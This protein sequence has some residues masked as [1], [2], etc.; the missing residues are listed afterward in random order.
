MN[1]FIAFMAS[2]TG[3][4]IRI[5]AGTAIMAWSLL[6]LHADSNTGLIITAMGAL[7]VLTGL[8]N[9]CLIAPLVG[10]PIAGSKA[11]NS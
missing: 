10:A 1:P 9:I 7:P 11:L 3:R 8:L 5:V 6:G 2:A 4:A